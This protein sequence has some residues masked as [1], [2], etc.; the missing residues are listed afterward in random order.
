VERNKKEYGFLPITVGGWTDS[1]T[2]KRY[3]DVGVGTD[4]L[5]IALAIARENSQIAIW[6]LKESKEIRV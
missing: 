1:A 4:A 2:G 3:V 6:D 5:E